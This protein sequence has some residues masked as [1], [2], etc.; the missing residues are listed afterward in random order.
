MAFQ[1]SVVRMNLLNTVFSPSHRLIQEALGSCR[2]WVKQAS[3]K[4]KG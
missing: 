3:F 4:I 1:I 2:Q